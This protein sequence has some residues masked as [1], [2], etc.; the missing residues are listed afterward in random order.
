[1]RGFLQCT[2]LISSLLPQV[3]TVILIC[4]VG[5]KLSCVKCWLTHD[6]QGKKRAWVRV[7][8]V[9]RLE[10]LKTVRDI[11]TFRSGSEFARWNPLSNTQHWTALC[12]SPVRGTSWAALS[13]RHR[14]LRLGTL[15]PATEMV[16]WACSAC[17]VLP[18]S[19]STRWP[20][21][22]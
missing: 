5:I 3:I 21:S 12:A 13:P 19:R 10:K 18:R 7:N 6:K 9:K 4:I 11:T 1:M 14:V 17:W 15:G 16:I 22:P 8:N 20:L 2:D